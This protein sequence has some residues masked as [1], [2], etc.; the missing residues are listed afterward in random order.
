MTRRQV[1]AGATAML[2]ATAMRPGA[3]AAN[4]A[5]SG[6]PAAVGLS[7]FDEI[8]GES[9]AI[10]EMRGWAR[11][12]LY[13]MPS[14]PE[15]RS[16]FI[17]GESGT[18]RGLLA[19]VLHA[20]GHRHDRP[21]VESHAGRIS[22]TL[23][24]SRLFGHESGAFRGVSQGAPG[25]FQAAHTGVLYVGDIAYISPPLQSK[26]MQALRSRTVQRMKGGHVESADVWLIGMSSADLYSPR[27]HA[28]FAFGSAIIEIPPLRDRGDDVLLLAEHYVERFAAQFGVQPKTLSGR[29]RAAL[30]A[31]DWA[32]NVR[33]LVSCAQR[34]V[35]LSR[36]R[37]IEPGDLLR[38]V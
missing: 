20:A 32:G 8:L 23:M 16:V 18:G 13:V 29:A 33:E 4:S 9:R 11:R 26:M 12:V 34:A 28:D 25:V 35:L 22:K 38:I 5:R 21:F 15:L 14:N 7:A 6:C 27:I 31:Y 19:K 10:S 37:T 3:W 2:A 1:L 17:R 24:E 30:R 36:G